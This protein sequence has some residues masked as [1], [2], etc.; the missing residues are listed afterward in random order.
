MYYQGVPDFPDRFNSAMAAGHRLAGELVRQ[1]RSTG[2]IVSSPEYQE[3]VRLKV[4]LEM[5]TSRTLA[6]TAQV[7]AALEETDLAHKLGRMEVER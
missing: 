5:E 7:A 4:I 3:I 2:D 6:E 1:E